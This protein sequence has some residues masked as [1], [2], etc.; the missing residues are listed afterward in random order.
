MTT[1]HLKPENVVKCG[2]GQYTNAPK[3]ID[4]AL[5]HLPPFIFHRMTGL[6]ATIHLCEKCADTLD[7]TTENKK[8]EIEHNWNGEYRVQYGEDQYMEGYYFR[9][10]PDDS[11]LT[12]DHCDVC[13][14]IEIPGY[15]YHLDI[16]EID[17]GDQMVREFTVEDKVTVLG[18]TGKI[19]G[20]SDSRPA[21]KRYH[22]VF[23]NGMKGS[24]LNWQMRRVK[25]EKQTQSPR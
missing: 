24:F 20:W 14:E 8:G 2:N 6:E 1:Q 3:V 19:T 16:D 13:R 4:A 15:T 9:Q 25:T 11:P 18:L 12:I 17:Y 21:K 22:I 10:Y 5:N 7:W 23:E